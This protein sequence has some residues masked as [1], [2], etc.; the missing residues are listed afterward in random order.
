MAYQ[1]VQ[2]P[3]TAAWELAARQH[4][5]VTRAQLLELGFTPQAILHRVCKR[6]LH[7]VMTGVFALGR[8]QLTQFGR[9]MA[10]VLACGEGAVLSHASAA[11]LWRIYGTASGV[12]HVSVPASRL[13]RRPGIT[14]HRRTTLDVTTHHGIPVTTPIATLIDI[15]P[16]LTHDE[17]EAAINEADKRG[18]TTPDQLRS[19]LDEVVPRPGSSGPWTRR[20]SS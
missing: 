16:T 6:R 9:W 20:P 14:V 3:G 15:A 1:S 7:P 2:S 17:R 8:P 10:A 12:I 13:P 18:L 11:A 4:G 19:T 5:V